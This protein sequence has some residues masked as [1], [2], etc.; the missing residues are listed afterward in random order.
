[1][2]TER[3]IH[4]PT[5]SKPSCLHTHVTFWDFEPNA[6]DGRRA[7]RSTSSLR[8]IEGNLA[9]GHL[10]LHVIGGR[11]SHFTSLHISPKARLRPNQAL[12]KKRMC[13]FRPSL[14]TQMRSM[15]CGL[16]RGLS[17]GSARQ[18]WASAWNTK[19]VIRHMRKNYVEPY[20][21]IDHHS[22]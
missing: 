6:W 10:K 11:N 13:F 19:Q 5:C 14:V 20:F 1:M 15:S 4:P 21:I 22:P 7:A 8:D 9:Q 18:L 3:Y 12:P 2:D 17:M 16:D